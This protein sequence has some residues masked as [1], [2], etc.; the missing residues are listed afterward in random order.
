M[1]DFLRPFT[2]SEPAI[3]AAEWVDALRNACITL[4][5]TSE[6]LIG[7][8]LLLLPVPNSP[9]LACLLPVLAARIAEEYELVA[10]LQQENGHLSVRL[11][12]PAPSVSDSDLVTGAEAPN[13]V[14][15]SPR[16]G[17][18]LLQRGWQ[19]IQGTRHGD[20]FRRIARRRG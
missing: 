8:I 11:R 16:D 6:P 4:E 14:E 19:L 7:S 5:R 20:R 2:S 10:E 12:R 17:R 1:S 3:S 15:P 9:E 18:G 13:H